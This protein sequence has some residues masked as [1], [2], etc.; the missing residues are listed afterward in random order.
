M[1][2]IPLYIALVT[3]IKEIKEKQ[4]KQDNIIQS[5]AAGNKQPLIPHLVVV[6][7]STLIDEE[8]ARDLEFLGRIK[9]PNLV[10]LTGY[11]VAEDHR[12]AIYEGV[13]V[14]DEGVCVCVCVS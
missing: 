10:P 3:E 11:C 13:C 6:A 8:A 9:H 5:I 1:L 4:Q 14:C 12:I 2:S 7:S